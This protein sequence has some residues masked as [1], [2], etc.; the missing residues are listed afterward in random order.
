MLGAGNPAQ[1]SHAP[2]Q[3]A[4]RGGDAGSALADSNP[5]HSLRLRL[6]SLVV[7]QTDSSPRC[8]R[9]EFSLCS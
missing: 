7:S 4:V 3:A 6:R 9:T 2:A 1:L 8:V 5:K